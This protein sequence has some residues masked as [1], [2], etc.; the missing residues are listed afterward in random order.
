MKV[1]KYLNYYDHLDPNKT[2]KSVKLKKCTILGCKANANKP[3]MQKVWN[4]PT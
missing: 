4:Q 1:A 3:D 2:G